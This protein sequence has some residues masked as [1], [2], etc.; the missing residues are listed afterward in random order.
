MA[1]RPLF[2]IPI[3]TTL[4]DYYVTTRFLDAGILVNLSASP[5]GEKGVYRYFYH[6]YI[7]ETSASI[8]WEDVKA[9]IGAGPD[10]LNDGTLVC[11]FYQN[12]PTSFNYD[13]MRFDPVTGTKTPLLGN[14][15]LIEFIP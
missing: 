8:A 10:L 9:E 2:D 14:A 5:P 7:Y 13:L 4:E 12:D 1:D 11:W 3:D 6:A 15:W